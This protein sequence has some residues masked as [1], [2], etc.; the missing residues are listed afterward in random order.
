[1]RLATC[2]Q[3]A[4]IDL[5]TIKA[6]GVPSLLLMEH[7]GIETVRALENRGLARGRIAVVTG[8]G[9]NAG[10]GLVIARLLARRG[11]DVRVHALKEEARLSA[12]A[13]VNLKALSSVSCPVQYIQDASQLQGFLS[14][15]DVIVDAI[16][17]TGTRGELREDAR[18]AVEAIN[19]SPGIRVCVDI[20]SGL[21]G[22][23]GMDLGAVVRGDFTVTYGLPKRGF[24]AGVGPLKTGQLVVAD[25]GFPE[26]VLTGF[27]ETHRLTTGGWARRTLPLREPGDHKYDHGR[28]LIIGGSRGMLGAPILAAKAALRSGVGLVRL[29]IPDDASIAVAA[30]EPEFLVTGLRV[31]A[32]GV[33][34]EESVLALEPLLAHVDSVVIGP[35]L[36]R[37]PGVRGFVKALLERIHSLEEQGH[38]PIPTVVDADALHDICPADALPAVCILTPHAGEATRLSRTASASTP[39]DLADADQRARILGDAFRSRIV[40]KGPQTVTWASSGSIFVNGTASPGLAVAGSGDIL[41]G[42]IGGLMAQGAVNRTR[43]RIECQP[44][45][46][47]AL[48]VYLHG[49]ASKLAES[50]GSERSLTP[51][52]VLD[53]IPRA[54]RDIVDLGYSSFHP[55]DPVTR[56]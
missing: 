10:D 9:N 45:E 15:A 16:L 12:D 51:Q 39:F 11:L 22:D 21:D 20:P 46:L 1:M 32:A 47:E 17:G 41:A 56:P 26:S 35:G 37:E 30:Q 6:F 29:A 40:L 25:I 24:F 28:V 54:F 34:C 49:L 36:S 27:A 19:S 13:G 2:G 38:D 5:E 53:F 52:L 44:G 7:A 31:N 18:T 48:A 4:M 8:G 3:M 50:I 33:V 23:L 43:K 55:L 14:D 42:L